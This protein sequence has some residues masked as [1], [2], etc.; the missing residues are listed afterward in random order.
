MR[1][2]LA[3]I[4]EVRDDAP[5]A[6]CAAAARATSTCWPSAPGDCEDAP[7]AVVAPAAHEQVLAVLQACSEAG[8]AV[9]PFGGG[10]SVVGGLEPE[11]AGLE[12]LVS[13]D[14]G[15]MDRVL[16]ARRALADRHRRSRAC[17]CPSSSARW[18]SA[19]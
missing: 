14:L 18:A 8:V 4:C 15:R 3:A 16:G 19:G 1:E 13:L 12:A 17:G 9:V 10:T 2:R 7:D 6:C 11:R 5:R